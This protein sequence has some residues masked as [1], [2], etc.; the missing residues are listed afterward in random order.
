MSVALAGSIVVIIVG[1]I[2]CFL[3][4]VVTVKKFK[5]RDFLALFSL[6]ATIFSFLILLRAM[7]LL[8]IGLHEIGWI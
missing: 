6:V 4:F 5:E 1:L 7:Y 3:G 2:G 8:R